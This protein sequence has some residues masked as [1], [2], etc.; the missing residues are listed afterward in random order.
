MPVLEDDLHSSTPAG[1]ASAPA[2]DLIPEVRQH[3]R[4]RR[5]RNLAIVLVTAALVAGLVV[6]IGSSSPVHHLTG[7]P[8]SSGAPASARGN[9][10]TVVPKQPVSLAVDPRGALYVGDEGRQQILRRTSGGRFRVV[11]GTGVAGYS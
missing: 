8:G 1:S 7:T 10:S 5:L 3:A 4:R 9:S 2:E 6:F 11:A